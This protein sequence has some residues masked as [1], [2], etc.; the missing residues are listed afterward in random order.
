[1][2]KR[3]VGINEL[4][5]YLDVSINTLRYWVWRKEIPY[6]KVGKSVKFDII[7]INDWLKD[8]KVKELS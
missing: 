5:K 3:F 6:F 1:M 4:A 7:E 8:K 2:E